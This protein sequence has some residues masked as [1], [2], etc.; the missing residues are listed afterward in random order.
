LFQVIV[1][2]AQLPVTAWSAGA[3]PVPLVTVSRN[4]APV[5]SDAPVTRKRR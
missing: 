1:D 5:R 3:S 2:S 4:L